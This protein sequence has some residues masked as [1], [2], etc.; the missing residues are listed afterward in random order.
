MERYGKVW[1]FGFNYPNRYKL[2]WRRE[3]VDK[4]NTELDEAMEINKNTNEFH[5]R[6]LENCTN[7]LENSESGFKQKRSPLI[8]V[9]LILSSR[10]VRGASRK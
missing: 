10:N 4:Q 5:Q 1:I 7:S 9:S 2:L 8:F 6:G 3:Y